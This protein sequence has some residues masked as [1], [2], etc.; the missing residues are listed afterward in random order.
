[1]VSI[2]CPVCTGH[3]HR[4]AAVVGDYRIA[5]CEDCGFVFV[6]PR[7]SEDELLALYADGSRNPYFQQTY[8]PLELELPTL[9]RVIAAVRRHV[10]TGRLLEIGCGR[11]DLL[12]VASEAGYEADGCD[13][14][15]SESVSLG[16]TVRATAFRGAGY[17]SALFD[18]VITRNTIEHLFDP[19]AE[20][21]EIRRVL[22]PGGR[23]YIKVP[24][25]DFEHGIRCLAVFGKLRAFHPPWHLNHFSARTLERFLWRGGFRVVEWEQELPTR[26]PARLRD[27]LQQAGFHVITLIRRLTAGRSF[28]KPV[29]VCVAAAERP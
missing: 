8:E 13:L 19:A 26:S 2:E 15:T 23:L 24:N 17:P 16:V 20:L 6:N 1:M 22:R 4:T 14:V 7:P 18:V 28:P 21:A 25:V 3:G 10:P 29:L 11:G 9:R 5:S 12:R 27:L